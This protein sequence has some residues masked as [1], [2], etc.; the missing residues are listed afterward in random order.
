MR[1]RLETAEAQ[2]NLVL[3]LLLGTA[4]ACWLWLLLAG[5][6][7]MGMAMASPTM[8]LAAPAFTRVSV[9]AAKL[10]TQTELSAGVRA[11]SAL[12][13]KA[14]VGADGASGRPSSQATSALG[15]LASTASGPVNEMPPAA[16]C[17][18]PLARTAA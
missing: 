16:R 17:T 9:F 10:L 15:S 18:R 7:D 6:G 5:G 8:G 3:G 13:L 4:A 12:A 14:P 11:S 2:R 1:V